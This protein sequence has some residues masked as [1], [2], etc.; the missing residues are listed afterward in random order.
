[1]R[2]TTTTQ[3]LCKSRVT[4]AYA[5]GI[6][7]RCVFAFFLPRGFFP[8]NPHFTL[9]NSPIPLPKFLI[10]S[11]L[12]VVPTSCESSKRLNML[13]AEFAATSVKNVELKKQGKDQAQKQV[14]VLDEQHKALPFG[15]TNDLRTNPTVIPD[16]SVNPRLANMLE[17]VV[18]MLE[19]WFNN[20]KKVCIPNYLVIALDDEIA[21]FY[22]DDGIDLIGKTRGNNFLQLRYSVLLSDVDIMYLQNTYDYL[23]RDSDVE[24]MTDGHNNLT[25]YGYDDVFYE[26][27]MGWARYAHIIRIWFYNSSF[28]YLRPTIPLIK[29]LDCV[30][31]WL[32]HEK[33]W[34]Q[35]VFN[36][37]L[38]F[39][40]HPRFNGLI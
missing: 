40:S 21:Y 28:F 3:S 34:D 15:T 8:F 38:F 23:Y 24:S 6:F 13:K 5:I 10:H 33:A 17:K 32:S 35:A 30:A 25:A 36:E 1:M 20:I 4:I 12:F 39:L 14:A 7:L 11:S 16:E 29:L 19:V 37:E 26:P 31:N 2:G 18:E 9:A 27:P 22:L